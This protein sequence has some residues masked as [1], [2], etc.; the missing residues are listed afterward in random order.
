M[1]FLGEVGL[2][3][4]NIRLDFGTNLDTDTDLDPGSIFPLFRH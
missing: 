4:R 1:K 2:R 3:I